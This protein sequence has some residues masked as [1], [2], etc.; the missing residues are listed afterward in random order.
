MS[1]FQPS[2]KLWYPVGSPSSTPNSPSTAT[3]GLPLISRSPSRSIRREVDTAAS[4]SLI[5]PNY[6]AGRHLKATAVRLS[7][8]TGELIRTQGE[9]NITIMLLKQFAVSFSGFPFHFSL[10]VDH[11]QAALIDSTIPL[12]TSGIPVPVS[13]PTN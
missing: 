8:A 1:K 2:W 3:S 6:L 12:S 7:S 10:L 13:P 11:T 9:I 5:P 4:V